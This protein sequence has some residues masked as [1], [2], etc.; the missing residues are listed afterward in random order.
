MFDITVEFGD[1]AIVNKEIEGV[2]VDWICSTADAR[3]EGAV[4]SSSRTLMLVK[5]WERSEDLIF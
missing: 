1:T 3:E 5:G 4:M 2:G